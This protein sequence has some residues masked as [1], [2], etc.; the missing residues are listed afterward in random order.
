MTA[1]SQ[2]FD[3][4]AEIVAFGRAVLEELQTEW[5]ASDAL[6]L[7]EKPWKWTDEHRAWVAAGRP[8]RFDPNSVTDS[9]GEHA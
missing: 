1:D 8:D 5:S 3:D 6:Y 2:W 4:R 9:G 7:F